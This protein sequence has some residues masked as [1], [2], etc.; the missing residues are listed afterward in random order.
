LILAD[1]CREILFLSHAVEGKVHDKRLA[2]EMEFSFPEA[3]RLLKDTG[4][5]G[6]EPEGALCVQPKKKPCGKELT[7]DEKA[8]N[9]EKSRER[10]VVEHSIGG[11][12][13]WRCV[14]EISRS[15]SY[16]Q[17]DSLSWYA[18]GLH[19]FRLRCRK[20]DNAAYKTNS[21]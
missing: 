4:F 12:K 16:D 2:D 19:N 5:Q 1:P 10:V 8:D 13:T 9:C 11:M 15:T 21:E 3:T 7:D 14:R 18:T 6:F 20:N 17:R